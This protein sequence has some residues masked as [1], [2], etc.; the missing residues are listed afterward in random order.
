LGRDINS[1]AEES[2]PALSPDGSTLFFTSERS[3]FTVPTAHRMDEREVARRL[4]SIL[5]GHGNLFS[6]PVAALDLDP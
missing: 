5:N 1:D 6:I 3:P 2:Y 4:H